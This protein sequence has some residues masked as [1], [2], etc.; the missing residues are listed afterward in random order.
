MFTGCD[1]GEEK[2]KG[3]YDDAKLSKV[4]QWPIEEL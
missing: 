2:C 3:Y 1:L 4:G